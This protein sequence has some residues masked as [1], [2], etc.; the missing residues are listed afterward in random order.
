MID[1]IDHVVLTTRDEHGCIDFYTRVLGMTLERYGDNRLALRF[2]Q[3][4][5]N[6]HQPG[7]DAG[8][9]ATDPRPGSL[10]LC[11]LASVPLDRVIARL[12]ECGIDIIA[13]PLARSGGIGRIR[14]VYVRDPDGNLVEISERVD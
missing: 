12:E 7:L 13:G 11:F 4:K 10:D 1:A 9:K 2:G 5:I 14:S 3:Q 6:V 8:L